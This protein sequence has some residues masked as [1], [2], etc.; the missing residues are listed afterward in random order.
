MA[1]YF[2]RNP[3]AAGFMAGLSM[4][5]CSSLLL[6]V[7]QGRSD[8]L[9]A[10]VDFFAGVPVVFARRLDLPQP[11]FYLFFFAYSGLNGASIARLARRW[12][13]AKR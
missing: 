1:N 3:G 11:L 13:A 7:N 8:A 6:W 5:A 10:A 4:A 2:T 12:C 9:I